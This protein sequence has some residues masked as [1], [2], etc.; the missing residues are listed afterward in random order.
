MF[1]GAEP[2]VEAG[3]KQAELIVGTIGAERQAGPAE[4]FVEFLGKKV[5]A[6]EL[7]QDEMGLPPQ[8]G[9]LEAFGSLV[10]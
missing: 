4:P 2:P 1:A 6:L 9:G 5:S 3:A 8:T 10:D 7:A